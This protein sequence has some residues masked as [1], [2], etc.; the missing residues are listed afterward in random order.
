MGISEEKDYGIKAT[1]SRA[2]IPDDDHARLMYYLN[3]I[4]SCLPGLGLPPEMM[5]YSKYLFLNDEA[6]MVIEMTAL[7]LSPDALCG[8]AI[9]QVEDGH[10]VLKGFRN[11]FYELTETSTLRCLAANSREG[12]FFKGQNVEVRKFMVFSNQWLDANYIAPIARILLKRQL[13]KELR[14]LMIGNQNNEDDENQSEQESFQQFYPPQQQRIQRQEYE[15]P[16]PRIPT[17]VVRL[18]Q[19][20][21]QQQSHQ[22]KQPQQPQQQ[23]IQQQTQQSYQSQQKQQNESPQKAQQPQ[24]QQLPQQQQNENPKD[25]QEKSSPANLQTQSST[26]PEIELSQSDPKKPPCSCTI[27]CALF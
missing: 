10:P 15:T 17:Q 1:G 25:K 12:V 4:S 13:E 7:L 3:S 23:P 21:T 16:P 8:K 27:T 9:F 19:P 6:K 14:Q 18:D 26:R 2:A 11:N 5:D 20:T 22:R 24:K